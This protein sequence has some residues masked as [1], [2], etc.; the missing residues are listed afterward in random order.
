MFKK[1]LYFLVIAFV[2]SALAACSG[3]KT[4]GSDKE[5]KI[6]IQAAHVV[7]AEA[8]QHAMFEKFKELVEEKSDGRIEM[9]IFPDGQ[10][11]GERE[12]VES[13]QAGNIQISSPSVG[14]LAN[15]S[16]ALE[17]FDFP[18]IFKDVESVYKVFDGQV[19]EKLL[20]GLED[21]GIIGLGYSENGWRHLSNSKG[22][23]VTPDQVKGLKLRTMEVPKHIAYWKELG[24]NPTPLPFTEVFTGL[25]QGVVE[26]VENPFQLIYT[27]KFHEPSKYITTTGHLFDPEIVIVNKDFFNSLSEEDQEI[28]QTSLDEAIAYLRELN[29][30]LDKEL[31]VKLEDEGAVIRDLSEEEH[32]A[33]VKASI[34]FYEKHAD[35]VDKEMLK[36][37]L[38]EAGNQELLDVIK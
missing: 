1:G 31:R 17:V 15:F 20:A 8:T 29:T 36:E 6:T 19:G 23:I 37:L 4:S 38:D 35:E 18:F 25:S 22:E 2:V 27:G 34:P 12:M 26:G 33:W 3:D 13:T 7:S 24:A 16:S 28:I 21:S 11:G 32:N 10:L 5:K 14:V 9:E 30:N